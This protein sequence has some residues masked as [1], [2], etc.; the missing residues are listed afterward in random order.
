MKASQLYAPTLRESPAEAELI[1]H[2]LMFRAGL[3]R[4]AAGGLYSYLPLGWRVIKKIS[5][6]IREEMDAEGGQE[7]MMPIL[8]PSEIWQESGRWQVYGDEMMRMRDRHGREFC[9]GPTHE[10][11]IT[12]LVRDELRS[13]KQLPLLIYQIQNKYRDEIR[14]RFGLMRSREF[15]MKDLYS[16]DKDE[17]GLDESYKKMFDAYTRIFTRCGLEFRPVEADSGAIGGSNSHEF[18]VLAQSGES[19]IAFCTNC[20]FAASDEKAELKIIIAPAEDEKPIEKVETPDAHTIELVKNFLQVPIEKTIKAVAFQD[21]DEKL[22]LAFVRGDHEANEIKILNASGAMHL[23]MAEESAIVA[24]G[25]SPGFMSPI[26]LKDGTTVIVDQTVMEMHNAVA[27]ANE[28]NFH[29]INVNPKRDFKNVIVA[30]IRKVQAGDPC[31]HCGHE[32]KMTRGIEVGQVFKLGTKYSKAMNATF[33][34]EN[35]KAKFFQ[36]GCYGIGVGRTMAAAIE[37][38][39]DEH[40]IIFPRNIAP[41]EV[42]VCPINSKDQAQ[43]EFAEKIYE[44]L[45]NSGID[46]L[47]DDRPERAGVKFKDCDLIGYPMRITISPKSLE[48]NSIEVKIRKS[49]EIS[50]LPR[51]NYLDQVRHIHK[52][53]LNLDILL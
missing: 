8:Q 31:P 42:V 1:S 33:L 21:D 32:L 5:Q 48:T 49:G 4:K 27:G 39:N 35:G 13:Y 43:L 3:I 34:D 47:L 40:G 14:P 23:H 6:I 11:M 29:F 52:Y 10:E 50:E 17:S 18:T 12:S 9:L 16:F 38:N 36:M 45:K 53:L 7:I 26:G 37:Q 46:A 51:D 20:D 25:G 30:D 19:S 24:A 22:I 44:E 41:F 2:K 15:I 28:K